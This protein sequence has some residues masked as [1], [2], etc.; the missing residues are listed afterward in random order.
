MTPVW[1][2]CECVKQKD[3][4][5]RCR[6]V[7]FA[8][9]ENKGTGQLCAKVGAALAHKE[10]LFS[11]RW[12]SGSMSESQY[13]SVCQYSNKKKRDFLKV[14]SKIFGLVKIFWIK[15]KAIFN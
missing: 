11:G 12:W 13:M 15:I 1:R 10:S 6:R 8:E 2:G 14:N 7:K 5:A 3:F 4:A 9:N